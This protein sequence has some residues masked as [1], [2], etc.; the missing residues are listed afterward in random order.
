MTNLL[1]LTLPELESWLA[2][3]GEPRFRARQVYEWLHRRRLSIKPGITCLWQ[4]NGRNTVTFRRWMEMD[5][6]YVENWSIWLDI[7]ILARTL[8]VVL[9]RHGAS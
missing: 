8:P 1:S 2:E 5:K 7:K 6:E 3:Q 4:V 9:L